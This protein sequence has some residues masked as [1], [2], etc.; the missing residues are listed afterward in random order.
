[1][2]LGNE[3]IKR[4]YGDVFY[5]A[6]EDFVNGKGEPQPEMDEIKTVP[7]ENI[8]KEELVPTGCINWRPKANSQ[9]LFILHQKELKE[10]ELTD[11][12][13]KIVQSI[14]IPFEAAGF[15]I[16]TDTP[17]EADLDELPNQFGVVF[18]LSL[19]YSEQNPVDTKNGKL[20]FAATLSQLQN[21]RQA[22]M[23]LWSQLK[24]IKEKLQ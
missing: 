16:L 7:S 5:I 15:G 21:D 22:K 17:N 12:L 9:V 19:N 20:F 6:K 1:M 8:E 4:L 13:K 23:E 14:E 18:D 3:D 24:S 10:K 2:K 11:L